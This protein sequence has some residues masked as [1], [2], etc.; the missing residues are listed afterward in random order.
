MESKK[1]KI[2]VPS[3]NMPAIYHASIPENVLLRYQGSSVFLRFGS[4]T[5]SSSLIRAS[6]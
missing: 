6:I 3:N 2:M 4:I 5:R 1:K